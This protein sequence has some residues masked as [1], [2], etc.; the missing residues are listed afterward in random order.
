MKPILLF[1]AGLCVSLSLYANDTKINDESLATVGD[2]HFSIALGVGKKTNP[3]I[4]SDDID[5]YIVPSFRYY[6][7][8]F[9]FDNGDLGY[10]FYQSERIVVSA[11]ARINDE[12]AYFSRWHP[13]NVFTNSGITI[14]SVVP[15]DNET[16]DSASNIGP[17]NIDIDN[18][19]KRKWALDAGL[20]LNWFINDSTAVLAQ[21]LTDVNSVYNGTNA[22]VE[23]FHAFKPKMFDALSVQTTVGLD[24]GSSALH[25][26]YYGI[27]ANDNVNL[28]HLYNARSGF[29]PYIK[30]YVGAPI[31]EH[32][33]A[34][35]SV[36]TKQL[37]QSIQDSP[38]V[39]EK[40][41][42]TSFIGVSYV[43]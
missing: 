8:S 41:V 38:I 42:T 33:K 36:K 32:W 43:F 29:S 27:S 34:F 7:D 25:N 35:F 16:S 26:Y 10:S 13:D 39:E 20:Q 12:N 19:S 28:Q 15:G 31:S 24:W 14:P 1:I 23:L 2:F 37:S 40:Q 17:E 3:L 6:G 22:K 5:L 30:L 4:D 21:L 18:I 11:L 9:Y